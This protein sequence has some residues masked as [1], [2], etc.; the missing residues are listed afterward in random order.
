MDKAL[1]EERKKFKQSFMAVH[2]SSSKPTSKKQNDS[3]KPEKKKSEKEKKPPSAQEKL[4]LA[5][6]KAMGGGSQFKFGV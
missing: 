2:S 3:E 6:L 5:Q 1:L 4:N